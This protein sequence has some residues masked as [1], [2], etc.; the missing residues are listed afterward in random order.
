MTKISVIVS[1]HKENDDFKEC[2][3][4]LFNQTYNNLEIII[5]G[6]DTKIR[7]TLDSISSNG[8]TIK[9]IDNK[10][11]SLLLGLKQVKGDYISFVDSNNYYDIDYYRLVLENSIKN[12]SDIVISNNVIINNK[13]KYVTGLT[14]NT[15]DNIYDNKDFNEMFY[16]QTGRKDRLN[17]L[18]NKFIKMD[19]WKKVEKLVLKQ[20]NKIDDL[21]LSVVLYNYAK[22]ISFCDN[23]VYYE[24]EKLSKKNIKKA[25]ENIQKIVD[26]FKC[27]TKFLKEQKKYTKYQESLEIWEGFYISKQIELNNLNDSNINYDYENSKVLKKFYELKNDDRSW[28]NYQELLISYNEGLNDI[29]K[30]IASSE[31]EVVSFDMFDTL[32]V[33]PFLVPSDMFSLLN[34]EFHKVFDVLNVL[35]FGI[36]RKKSEMELRYIKKKED[37]K[38]VTYDEI[39]DYISKQYNLDFKKLEKIKQKEIEMELHFCYRRNTGYELYS[40]A[41]QLNKRVIL[42]SDIYFSKEVL[43]KILKKNGYE[44]DEYYVSSELLKTKGYGE[45]FDY[46]KDKEKTDKILHI[47]DN[48]ISDYVNP[49]E[50]GINAAR[51]IKTS[52]VIMGYSPIIVN[53]CGYLYKFFDSFNIDHVPYEQN[54]GVRCSIALAANYYFD[55]PFRPFNKHSDFNGDPYFIGY[56]A[57]GMQSVS[58]CKWLIDDVIKNKIDSICFMARDGYLLYEALKIFDEKV[59]RLKNVK[60]NYTYVSRKSLMPLLFREKACISLIDTYLEYQFLTPKSLMKQFEKVTIVTSDAKK[61]ISLKY[62]LDKEFKCVED[63]NDCLSLIY[64]YCFDQKKYDDYYKMCKTYFDKEFIGNASTFDVG[65]SGKPEAIISSI[66][67][68]PLTTYFIHTNSTE[69]FKNSVNGKFRLET[70]YDFKPTISGALRELFISYIGPSCV[71]YKYNKGDVVP[72]FGQKDSYSYY[73]IDMVQLSQKGA[74]D[75]V[76]DF[77]YFFGEYINYLDFNK[78]YMSLPLEYYYHYAKEIDKYPIK[79]LLFEANV[80]NFVEMNDFILD[81]KRKYSAEYNRGEKS[82]YRNSDEIDYTLPKRRINRVIYYTLHDKRELKIK[83]NKWKDKSKDP[84]AL[85]SSKVKRVAYYTIFD[86]KTLR[87]KFKLKKSKK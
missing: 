59:G 52:D 47:G 87:K 64:D 24:Q 31:T 41:K 76:K 19:L 49:R 70:F 8:K 81:I 48:Y 79:D 21:F 68:R 30:Q 18:A 40:L 20:N 62:D 10:Q 60:L 6:A 84:N 82:T 50:H 83:W 71:G 3:N 86:R 17:F 15:N 78:Y 28:N 53:N 61:K 9:I 23:A 58:M 54:T 13:K 11:D 37:I 56:Y 5:I 29:K 36:I 65:Y 33:R 12:N 45:V 57:L 35:D 69:G 2:L 77:S 25:N 85:P 55:N 27:I 63:F 46:V 75:F 1:C 73:N 34:A 26:S 66:I 7:K 72:V 43:I 22:T 51:L 14:F 16:Q 42:T 39:Y 32:V 4:S 38:E 67:Q 74:I 80:N 44:F